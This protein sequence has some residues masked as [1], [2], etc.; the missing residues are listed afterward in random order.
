MLNGSSSHANCTVTAKGDLDLW[1]EEVPGHSRLC[2][3]VSVMRDGGGEMVVAAQVH[4]PGPPG[5]GPAPSIYEQCHGTAGRACPLNMV[6]Q[7]RRAQA[8]WHQGH[9]LGLIL[10]LHSVSYA[11]PFLSFFFGIT[12]ES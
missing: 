9:H 2:E 6:T 10:P 11:A 8:A 1:V 5:S 3:D 12:F 4:R 7:Q